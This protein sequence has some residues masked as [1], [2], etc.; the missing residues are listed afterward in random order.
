MEK[1]FALVTVM[2]ISLRGR[3]HNCSAERA[4]Q[5]QVIPSSASYESWRRRLL[6]IAHH[7]HRLPVSS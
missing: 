6:P 1:L 4:E 3:V 5:G 2:V 7:A